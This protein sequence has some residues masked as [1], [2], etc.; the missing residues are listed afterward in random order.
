[1]STVKN[2]QSLR[3]PLSAVPANR[4]GSQQRVHMQNRVPIGRPLPPVLPPTACDNISQ[5][6]EA[7]VAGITHHSYADLPTDVL[8][9]PKSPIAPS[10]ARFPAAF[11][12]AFTPA[13]ALARYPA[14]P[15]NASQENVVRTRSCTKRKWG[16]A[17]R[18]IVLTYGFRYQTM[19]KNTY[20]LKQSSINV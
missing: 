9:S 12:D 15:R 10:S 5:T 4:S 18:K 17:L 16:L 3:T 8:C 13:N 14:Q 19:W 6:Q 7:D 20:T 1:M 11:M 2:Q